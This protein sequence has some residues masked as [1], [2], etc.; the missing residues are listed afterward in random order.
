[1]FVVFD[2]KSIIFI[3]I[4]MIVILASIAYFLRDCNCK[5][6]PAGPAGPAGQSI[7][8]S[9]YVGN[10]NVT[11]DISASGKI[12][13]G[14]CE[15]NCTSPPTPIPT[16]SSRSSSSSKTGWIIA[17][18]VF[19]ILVVAGVVVYFTYFSNY[20]SFHPSATSVQTLSSIK[21]QPLSSSISSL[22]GETPMG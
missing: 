7:D 15:L 17:S 20:K 8:M 19:G 9:N 11:G 5:T 14:Q 16:E 2:Y 4:A 10:V 12:K 6:G 18:V 3:I 22:S 21:D 13:S 1:M